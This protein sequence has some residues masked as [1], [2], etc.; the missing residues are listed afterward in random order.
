LTLDGSPQGKTAWLRQPYFKPPQGQDA[1][2][3]GYGVVKDADAL[4]IYKEA[5]ANR[6][7]ILSHTN[8]DRAIDQL[9]GSMHAAEQA[10]P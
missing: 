5:L 8:G 1:S 2:Y 9:L 6:W 4:A 7:Q 10:Y 3:A